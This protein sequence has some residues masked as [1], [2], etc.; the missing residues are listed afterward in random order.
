MQKLSVKNRLQLALISL[1]ILC[2]SAMW[3]QDVSVRTVSQVKPWCDKWIALEPTSRASAI[4]ASDGGMCLG[5]IMGLKEQVSINPV[6]DM[7]KKADG[8]A[9]P[10][11]KFILGIW[12]E[13]VTPDQIARVFVKFVADQPQWLDKPAF[14]AIETACLDMGL[15]TYKPWIPAQSYRSIP[16][17]GKHPIK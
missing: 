16:N 12:G 3:S 10:N 15:L 14:T 13:A 17:D 11:G 7:E 5:Y 2:S 1:M 4:D 6:P 8:T 9:T